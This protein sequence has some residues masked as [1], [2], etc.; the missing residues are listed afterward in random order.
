MQGRSL[1]ARFKEATMNTLILPSL[2][3]ANQLHLYDEI[4]SLI[5][6][7]ADMLH[8]DVGREAV[9]VLSIITLETEHAIHY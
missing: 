6:S 5:N 3:C 2:M 9:N 7:G 8:I 4:Q 1:I